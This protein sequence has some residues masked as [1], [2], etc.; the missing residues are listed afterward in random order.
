MEL[1]AYN[2]LIN[3]NDFE[4][5]FRFKKTEN[6]FED[7]W[8]MKTTAREALREWLFSMHKTPQ[9]VEVIANSSSELIENCIKY[10]DQGSFS[11][12]LMR[13]HGDEVTIE[14]ANKA[15]PEL[16]QNVVRFVEYITAKQNNPTEIYIKKITES[17][18]TGKSQLGLL[19]ILMETEGAMEVVQDKGEENIVHL[20]VTIKV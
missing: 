3:R 19:K 17:L 16:K 4:Y 15:E 1:L 9:M 10:S 2:D 6:N 5:F 12:V 8:R 18:A 20:K 14:T 13:V 11:F 7:L